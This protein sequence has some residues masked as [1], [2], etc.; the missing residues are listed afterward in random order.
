MSRHV[1]A[2]RFS[3]DAEGS[4]VGVGNVRDR[5]P[6]QRRLVRDGADLLN[7]NLRA[8]LGGGRE[9]RLEGFVV[10]ERYVSPGAQSSGGL[11]G[12]RG[13]ILR[14]RLRDILIQPVENEITTINNCC[15]GFIYKDQDLL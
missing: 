1:F 3:D 5:V 7:G 8:G 13:G 15:M 12:R 10:A 6:V 9:G 11:L 2:V 14:C 4:R